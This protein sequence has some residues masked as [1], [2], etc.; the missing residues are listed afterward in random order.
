M[1]VLKYP[2]RKS[3]SYIS[4][5]SSIN[6]YY[7]TN[8]DKFIYGLSKQLDANTSYVLVDIDEYTTLD[9][10]AN[11]YYGRPD[12]FWVIADFN[13]IQD[14]FITLYPKYKQIKIPSIATIQTK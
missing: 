3:Y 5:Y 13:R 4:R 6:Y 7:N 12:Y 9:S 1:D 8:D 11:K 2:A 10:L 14:P